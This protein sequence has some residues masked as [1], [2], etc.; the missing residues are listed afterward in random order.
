MPLQQRGRPERL[1]NEA[2]AAPRDV[3]AQLRYAL[4]LLRV[5]ERDQAERVL[6]DIE[7]LDPRSADLHFL[8]AELEQHEHRDKAIAIL[9]DMAQSKQDGYAVELLLGKLLSAAGDD[10]AARGALEKASEFDPLS[11]TP[12]YLL[13]EIAQNRADD[14]AELEQLRRLGELEQ[15]EGKVYRRLLTL[16]IA[17]KGWDEAVKVG[18]SAIYADTEGFTTHRLFG[19]ALA[20][21]GNTER[22]AFELESATLSPAEPEQ[23]AEAHTRLAELYA[24]A[25]R[26]RDAARSRKRAAELRAAAPAP[27]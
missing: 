12:H 9:R 1:A 2:K 25:G 19:E 23:L 7:K 21:T 14:A 27:N 22:A 3:T 26:S 11:A 24:S 16:L 4:S 6:H 8:Q 15:H 10:A 13:A 20:Q 17:K 5:G 18:E